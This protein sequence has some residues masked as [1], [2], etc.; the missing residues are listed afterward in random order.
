MAIK[1]AKL[2]AASGPWKRGG[3]RSFMGLNSVDVTE[4]GGSGSENEI[5]NP[6]ASVF[7]AFDA[8][9]IAK[10]G[11]AIGERVVVNVNESGT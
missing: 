10:D 4:T 7:V 8:L 5:K 9:V 6:K 2:K 1:A 11:D 3:M